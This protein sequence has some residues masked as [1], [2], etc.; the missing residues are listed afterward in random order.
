V[1]QQE[2]LLAQ[3]AIMMMSKH[4]VAPI[5]EHYEIFYI[6]SAGSNPTIVRRIDETIATGVKFTPQMLHSLRENCLGTERTAKAMEMVGTNIGLTLDNVLDKLSDAG[7][8]A[9]E[10]GRTLSTASGSLNASQPPVVLRTMVEGLLGATKSMEVRTKNLE[11]ELKRSS[12]QI[13]DLRTQLDM[14]RKESRTDALTGIANRKTF[15]IELESAIMDWRENGV[16]V[17]LLMCD[18]DFFKKFND[19]WGHQTGDQVLR[20][21][22]S[23]LSENVKG[24]D[25]AARY[26]GEEFAVILR[27][28]RVNDAVNLANQI[29]TCIESRKLIKKSTG[30]ILGAITVS[31]GVAEAFTGDSGEELIQHADQC[32]YRAKQTGRNRVI[33]QHGKGI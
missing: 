33:G 9:G 31:I 7:K 12:S 13:T 22:A 6:Y 17:S 32:L 3:N 2:L 11:G 16:P 27:H 14:V 20:L 30:E 23:C 29:R 21:V 4:G 28:T 1:Q 25:T 24:R 15:D 19:T 18:I 5:P 10:Y 26:G 8:Q